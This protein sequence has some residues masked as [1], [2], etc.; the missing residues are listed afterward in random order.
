[1]PWLYIRFVS[2]FVIFILYCYDMKGLIIILISIYSTGIFAQRVMAVQTPAFQKDLLWYSCNFTH[3]RSA[4]SLTNTGAIA[5]VGEF[6]EKIKY[7]RELIN[8]VNYS[9]E[10]FEG[11]SQ[12]LIKP[13]QRLRTYKFYFS[14]SRDTTY[15][16]EDKDVTRYKKRPLRLYVFGSNGH[17]GLGELLATP[18]EIT[19]HKWDKYVMNLRASKE[20]THIAIYASHD[21]KDTTSQDNDKSYLMISQHGPLVKSNSVSGRRM[22]DFDPGVFKT[23][24]YSKLSF[25]GIEM[26]YEITPEAITVFDNN[27]EIIVSDTLRKDLD[28]NPTL[29]NILHKFRGIDFLFLVLKEKKYS[30][31][32]L[33]IISYLKTKYPEILESSKVMKYSTLIAKRK[34]KTMLREIYDKKNEIGDLLVV[35]RVKEFVK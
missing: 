13:M 24:S 23:R 14:A 21:P 9:N 11:I 25:G 30:K 26:M 20:W 1:M 18:F 8:L 33:N 28:R 35:E 4:D 19:N 15:N 5:A 2:G 6:K 34:N 17:C 31:K 29:E 7:E 3:Y 12:K 16:F 32:R 27:S 22:R 10:A